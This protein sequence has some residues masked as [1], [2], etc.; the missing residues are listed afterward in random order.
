MSPSYQFT[1]TYFPFKKLTFNIIRVFRH[2]RADDSL[3]PVVAR[4]KNP[5]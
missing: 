5:V 2:R 4:E 1:F 3:M